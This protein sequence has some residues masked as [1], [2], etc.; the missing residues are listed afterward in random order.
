M[1]EIIPQ[2]CWHSTSREKHGL[3]KCQTN[4]LYKGKF[5]YSQQCDKIVK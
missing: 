1:G 2:T 5:H 4:V 3:F